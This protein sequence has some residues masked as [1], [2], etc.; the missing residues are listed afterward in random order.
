M[1]LAHLV[2]RSRAANFAVYRL[3]FGRAR[4]ASTC[5]MS[6]TILPR[7]LRTSGKKAG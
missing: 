7:V 6:R 4:V 2:E 1:E 3:D 5:S